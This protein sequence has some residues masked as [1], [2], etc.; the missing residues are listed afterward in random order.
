MYYI[1][2]ADMKFKDTMKN[3]RKK[4]ELPLESAMPCKIFNQQ[5]KIR[6]T[7]H[8]AHESARTRTGATQ[9]RDYEDLIAQKGFNSLTHYNL[10]HKPMPIPQGMKFPHAKAAVDKSGK[11]SKSCRHGK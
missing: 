10:V 11:S 3:A 5:G 4:M 1:D 2:P 8:N 6:C 9:P 7:Q